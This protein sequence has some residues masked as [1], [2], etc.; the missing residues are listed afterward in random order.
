[1][2][3]KPAIALL[4]CLAPLVARAD[5]T[6]CNSSANQPLSVAWAF[7]Y[8]GVL[9]MPYNVGGWEHIGP[10]RCETLA[11]GEVAGTSIWLHAVSKHLVLNRSQRSGPGRPQQSNQQF[12]ISDRQF[13][14]EDHIPKAARDCPAGYYLAPF[15]IMI[16]NAEDLDD[17]T[18][19][20]N[21]DE[22][23]AAQPAGGSLQGPQLPDLHGALA[24]S[25]TGMYYASLFHGS[26]G[27]ARAEAMAH[28]QAQQPDG[29]CTLDTEFK[30]QC[31]AAVSGPLRDHVVLGEENW[32]ESDTLSVALQLCKQGEGGDC[33]KILAACSTYT[34]QSAKRNFSDAATQTGDW[35][36]PGTPIAWR[37]H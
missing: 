21:P 11:R 1:M 37:A 15:P 14:Y 9:A 34:A 4:A 23:R 5:F 25:S 29:Q 22:L 19:G 10:N 3:L 36:P 31:L 30:N 35:Q 7:Q 13:N 32:S 33:H 12:C 2:F 20:L 16:W 17:L 27:H 28:C 24:I 18:I 8:R 6:V 26:A